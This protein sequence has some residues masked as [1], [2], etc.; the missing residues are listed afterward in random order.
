MTTKYVF[1]T[2]CSSGIGL[3]TAQY[4]R[5]RDWT[6]YASVRKQQDFAALEAL[7]CH[8]VLCNMSDTNAINQAAQHVLNHSQQQCLSLIHNAGYA[9]PGAIEDI[10]TAAMLQQFQTNFFGVHTLSR[11]FLPTMR[12]AN[13][14]RIIMISS[15]L[16]LVSLPFRGAYNASKH[17]LEA[18]ASALRQ[19]LHPSHIHVSVIQPGP[20]ISAFRKNALSAYFDTPSDQPS[21]HEAYYQ[22]WQQD[23][24]NNRPIPFSA[25][26]VQVAKRCFHAASATSPKPYYK[27][28]AASYLLAIL[29]NCMPSQYFDYL[30]RLLKF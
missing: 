10:S 23:L 21:P 29:H 6:V 20:I 16:G 18:M 19:E 17:A 22:Q 26:P 11:A 7:G 9:Q 5:Q 28:T 30:A 14:G 25:P 1:I 24:K 2:G 4:F 8:P 3:A 27:V 12:E 15:I 13:Q